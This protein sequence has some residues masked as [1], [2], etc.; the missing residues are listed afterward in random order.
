V[1]SLGWVRVVA[2]QPELLAGVTVELGA[3]ERE[4]IALGRESQDRLALL[5]DRLAREHAREL[6]VAISGTLGVL[7]RAKQVGA[8][9]AL[10]PLL[11]RLDALRFRIDPVT[12]RAALQLAGE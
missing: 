1:R 10:A 8:V 7:I 4:V 2:A 12:R 6:G 5:D 9:A 11:D 3:G